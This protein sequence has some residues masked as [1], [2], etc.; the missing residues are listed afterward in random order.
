[1]TPRILSTSSIKN[2][3][4]LLGLLFLFIE[5]KATSQDTLYPTVNASWNCWSGTITNAAL[6]NED[7]SDV[8]VIIQTSV[9]YTVGAANVWNMLLSRYDTTDLHILWD[10][11]PTYS[12]ANETD[13]VYQTRADVPAGL[14]GITWCDDAIST[15]R[16]DQHYVAFRTN[17]PG[18]DLACHE[19]G[20]AVGL[21]H[22]TQSWPALID[23]AALLECMRN[24]LAPGVSTVGAVNIGNINGFY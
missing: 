4:R 14:L 13:I 19:T 15:R 2:Q 5:G 3:L 21:V 10:L 9:E 11:S 16:C 8:E 24:P 1:M 12:G 22:G 17:V 20:H 7:D 23:N 18:W 6:C